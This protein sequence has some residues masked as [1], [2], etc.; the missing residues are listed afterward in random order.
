LSFGNG[1][2]DEPFSISAWVKMTDASDFK[3]ITKG[4]FGSTYEYQLGITAS[5]NGDKLGISIYGSDN[6]LYRGR[7]YDTLGMTGHEGK[8]THIV[9]TY[10]G[11]ATCAGCAL[12]IN[13]VQVDDTDITGGSYVAMSNLGAPAY[14]GCYALDKFSNG[15]MKFVKL[16]SVGLTQLQVNDLYIR[17]KHKLNDN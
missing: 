14:V 1:T 11:D 13:G 6:S 9:G 3:L 5:V 8:W 15:D 4:V 2:T 12:Y 10:N 7:K 16:Y 17:E